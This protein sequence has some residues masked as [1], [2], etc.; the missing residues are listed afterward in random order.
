VPSQS[1]SD[2]GSAGHTPGGPE[3]PRSRSARVR[4]AYGLRRGLTRRNV[5][6]REIGSTPKNAA[7][8]SP[9]VVPTPTDSAAPVSGSVVISGH[10]PADKCM[11][12]RRRSGR[13][14]PLAPPGA[15][16]S[17]PAARGPA[18]LVTLVDFSERATSRTTSIGQHLAM[19]LAYSLV[20]AGLPI[21]AVAWVASQ[22]VG[23]RSWAGMSSI[24]V[25]AAAGGMTIIMSRFKRK[26][27]GGE[28]DR[29]QESQTDDPQ[30]G[31]PGQAEDDQPA[32]ED[33]DD[34]L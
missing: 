9:T 20:L 1:S 15:Q 3:V 31:R 19:F 11:D 24:A 2:P 4:S 17:P 23:V 10:A 13:L 34:P 25:G 16:A 7:I 8:P 33:A 32:A 27:G 12:R 22:V 30:T 14:L 26:I 21:F 18:W 28:S 6:P 29:R 5:R